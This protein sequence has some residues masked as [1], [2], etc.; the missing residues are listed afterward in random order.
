MKRPACLLVDIL[1]DPQRAEGLAP[2]QWD[3][4]IRQARSAQLLVR[5][6]TILDENGLIGATPEQPRRHLEATIR[7][8]DRQ[9]QAVRWEVEYLV[10]ALA[11]AETPLV[12]LKGAAYEMAGLA[13]GRC[14]IFS[15]F[16]LLVPRESLERV[17]LTLMMH[18][19]SSTHQDAYDQRYY[20]TWMHEL[21]PLRH[22]TRA[23]VID[24]HHNLVPD[25][26]RLRPDPRKLL[27]AT[28]PCPG[29]PEIHVLCEADMILHSAIHLFHDGEFDHALRD[30]F[31][32]HDLVAPYATDEARWTRLTM[33]AAELNLSRPLYYALRYL[34]QMLGMY[35][36]EATEA[37]LS[38]FAPGPR[39]ASLFDEVFA[40]GL[41][42]DNETCRDWLCGPARFALYV[43][44]HAL[45]MPPHL[46]LPHLARKA[47]MKMNLLPD[48]AG[49]Q[50]TGN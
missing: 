14:R 25:T 47:M 31:D 2:H 33:R 3:T 35:V 45:R 48:P 17:E 30:L 46:L 18:G 15:D 28:V 49:R 1:L 20:R 24:V 10:L 9:R 27:A 11:Q 13:P 29:R 43:R 26:A 5:L 50:Q 4:L 6:A 12:L 37:A 38:R 42:P 40:R 39:T 19:W 7:L 36:P 34:N 21:P 8:R 23:S 22:I 41:L 32:L 16:D 44:G